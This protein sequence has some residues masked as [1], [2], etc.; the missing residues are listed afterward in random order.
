MSRAWLAARADPRIDGMRHTTES[1]TPERD[2][3]YERLGR[4]IPD[5]PALA[6]DFAHGTIN[7]RPGLDPAQRELVILGAL[8]AT[9]AVD[10]QLRAHVRAALHA[11]LDVGQ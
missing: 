5:L 7:S 10:V 3:V 8:L 11:G 2:G 6:L 9:G 4:V 1:G